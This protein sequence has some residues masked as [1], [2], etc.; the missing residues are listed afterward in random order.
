MNWGKGI[1]LG[2]LVF[3][4]FIITMAVLMFL[5]P[6]DEYDHQYYEKGLTFDRDYNRE[7]GVYKDHV[8]PVIKADSRFL[9][10]TFA[11]PV[12]DGKLILT[13]PADARM[14]KTFLLNG[15]TGNQVA[16]PL[17]QIAT[18]HWQLV[19]NWQSSQKKYLYQQGIYIK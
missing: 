8:Q 2:M 10:L 14:D 4:A 13:R 12:E 15:S 9:T 17:K 11:Q 18:G 1:I 16:I 3:M 7:A 6:N 5:A 19:L